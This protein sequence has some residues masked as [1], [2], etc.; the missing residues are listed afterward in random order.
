MNKVMFEIPRSCDSRLRRCSIRAALVSAGLIV[1]FAAS[2]GAQRCVAQSVDDTDNQTYDQQATQPMDQQTDQTTEQD[3]G[4]TPDE[5]GAPAQSQQTGQ[6]SDQSGGERQNQ[7]S[8]QTQNQ[9]SD[10][11]QNQQSGQP[12]EQGSGQAPNQQQRQT[13]SKPQVS[14]EQLISILE[15]E[16]LVLD[17]VR[18]LVAKR[19]HQE[20]DAINDEIIYERIRGD[21]SLR[22]L[23]MRILIRRG[24]GPDLAVF[25]DNPLN[26][27]NDRQ[28]T[29]N[30]RRSTNLPPPPPPPPAYQN[31]DNPQVE[32]RL[33]PYMNMP[34]LT[35]L[36]S[37][38]PVTRPKLRRF[39]SEAFLIGNENVIPNRTGAPN[40]L[41]MDLPAGPDY[42]LGSGDNL[43]V[44]IWGGR[45]SRL[46]RV[47]DRQGEVDLPE[48]GTV[49]I[50]G[51]TIRQAEDAI[52]KALD[53]QFEG[54][55]VEISLGKLRSV[56]VY[57]VG[58]VQRPG[59]YDVSS[60][61]TP[62]G[63]LYAA[64]GPTG[65][66]SLRIL[67]QYR[68]KQLVRQ[69][70]LYDFLLKGVRSNDDRLLPG[71]TIL[72]PPAG[73]QVSVEGAVRRPAIYEL[74]GE[75][76][77][78]QV[79]D[80]AGGL[81]VSA[82]L[83]QIRVERIE[84]HESRTM[85]SLQLPEAADE[86]EAKLAAFKVQDGDDVVLSQIMPYNEQAVF[87]EGHVFHPGKYPY[88]D[89]MT[90]SDVLHS[91]EDVLPE[92]SDHAELI[93]LEPPDL[94]PEAI[95]LNLHDVLIGNDPIPLRPFDLIRIYGRYEV[96]APNVIINGDVLRPGKYPMSEGMTVADL[97]RLAGGFKR[98]AFT[99]EGDLASYSTEDG[100]RILINHSEVA[101][102]KALDGDKNADVPLKPGDVVSIRSLAGWQDI[103][104]TVAI[105]GEVEHAG[106]YG[107][108]D[109]ERLSDVLKRAG[110]FR[111]DA[112]PYAA[113]LERVQVHEL[114]V[115]ARNAMIRRI[116][117]TP[118]TVPTS[119]S[120]S[121][122]SVG[123]LQSTLE[124][125]KQE[126]LTS[127]RNSTVSGRM[128]IGIGSDISKWANTSADIV[129]RAGDTLTIPKRPEF[130]MTSGQVYNSVAITYVPGKDL[131]WYLKK[132]GGATRTG[133]KR[134][135]Y[136]LRADGSV[137]PRDNGWIGSNF[138]DL[139]MRPG[140]TIVVP[141]KIGGGSQ[142]WERVS[143][144]AQA[145]I[146]VMIPLAATGVL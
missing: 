134:D 91:Y 29:A 31:P 32:Q 70:D 45:S 62:L 87:L 30:A 142:A 144:L 133:N 39:G 58:D 135:I 99:V 77:L 90:I 94:K 145:L 102:Q 131:S 47:I 121:N 108:Q 101:L 23:V 106:S 3:L 113:I 112:Y 139:R 69:F 9:Q 72:V 119:S 36:Y 25:S 18:S 98:S 74:N 40:Q 20:P 89:G 78:N 53:T 75:Q 128:V 43:I 61:S 41:P 54:E 81:L 127:L 93:R 86:L 107:I 140:D 143:A 1:F 60:L 26:P 104:A 56:R 28:P 15:R 67:R 50:D 80:L 100:Q 73:P 65:H 117:E 116:E 76:G 92:P 120:S 38:F 57:V 49:M 14:A 2:F 12:Q 7:R 110:G 22:E 146:A 64:G 11:N 52:Q 114:N 97:V 122:Q 63:A 136:V 132:A 24:Y 35:E 83:K 44:N 71:D 115:Q 66:G 33:S 48:A 27:A 118:V 124:T 111:K 125:Q 79:L 137:V 126:L 88:K 10:Q 59:A 51:M 96:D 42:V 19:S 82:N 46:T 95:N 4:L 129:V 16:P 103:G 8:G 55:H 141:E 105:E 5:G 109:G 13:P 21:V 68:G 84:A 138:M 34:S 130:V 123:S 85:F 37:Q 6:P 17:D